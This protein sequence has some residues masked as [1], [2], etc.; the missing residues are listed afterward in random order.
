[1]NRNEQEPT[2]IF[3]A[4]KNI[5]NR[6]QI[7][8][9]TPGHSSG[10]GTP[11]ELR[12]LYSPQYLKMDV[13]VCDNV[14]SLC[15]PQNF[16]KEA[17]ELLAKSYGT[18]KS[19]Y[20]VNGSTI[21]N[22]AMMMA[23]CKEGDYVILPRNAHKSI[24]N[25]TILA[26]IKPIWIPNYVNSELNIAYNL[27]PEQIETALLQHPEAKA[28]LISSP[29]Y[30]G[31]TSDIKEISK[32][33]HDHDKI[34]IVDEAWGAHFRYNKKFP[35]SAVGYADICVQSMH[36][37]LPVTNQGAIMHVNSDKIDISRVEQVLSMMHTTSPSYVLLSN[38]DLV[39][40]YLF[41]N[42][43]NI[44]GKLI[45]L[46]DYTHKKINSLN[47]FKCISESELPTF[48][49]LDPLKIT[50]KIRKIG[51]T[52]YD[53]ERILQRK[54][55]IQIEVSSIDHILVL[56]K[57]GI[58]TNDINKLIK[59]LKE[60]ESTHRNDEIHEEKH[61]VFPNFSNKVV[62][63]PFKAFN[64]A[65]KMVKLANST[66]RISGSAVFVY[67]PGIPILLPGERIT[68]EI[69]YYLEFLKASKACIQGLLEDNESIKIIN[70]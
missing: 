57:P 50:I 51:L 39:R 2:P 20:L 43:E 59:A 3:S 23:T 24:I 15:H 16:I 17:E 60:I 70:R 67:P 9:Q 18:K 46:S 64:S 28:V 27:F 13:S 36:K 44:Y 4:I 19:F 25:A 7:S 34:L 42:G 31:L 33:V 40:K 30:S 68:K 14:D 53:L 37:T 32:I 21:G 66:N 69:I 38:M 8:L 41:F 58:S 52:G 49:K 62:M 63:S 12:K 26:K 10:T 65:G 1:M 35:V 45:E 22:L 56:L 47:C 61:I 5:A 11:R 29:T 48:F 6:N 55:R 54:Y